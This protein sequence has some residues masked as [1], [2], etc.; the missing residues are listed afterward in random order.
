MSDRADDRNGEV[1]GSVPPPSSW[2]PADAQTDSADEWV[3]APEADDASPSASGEDAGPVTEDVTPPPAGS[4]PPPTPTPAQPTSWLPGGGAASEDV[5]SEGPA[6][7]ADTPSSPPPLVDMPAPLTG[8]PRV[9]WDE[10][11]PETRP[12]PV[13]F[14]AIPDEPTAPEPAPPVTE[15]VEAP[16]PGVTEWESYE[17]VSVTNPAPSAPDPAP[18]PDPEPVFTSFA[19]SEPAPAPIPEPKTAPV[20]PE[21][22]PTA[23]ETVTES[24][25][26]SEPEPAPA[27]A[28]QPTYPDAT[29][30]AM[31][32]SADHPEYLIAAA[33]IGGFLL[34]KVVKRLAA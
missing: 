9:P 30:K 26:I 1:K 24:T 16:A 10:P 21:P 31:A 15:P 17:L 13:S 22:T 11:A 25:F 7:E 27:F 2:V 28:A 34:A 4:V 23:F 14:V 5:N 18:T 32:V 3:V 19:E 12:D 29:E 20:A 6:P 33:L 8:A